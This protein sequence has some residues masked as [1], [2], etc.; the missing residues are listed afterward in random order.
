MARGR[1][2]TEVNHGSVV[3]SDHKAGAI[4]AVEHLIEKKCTNI[5]YIRPKEYTMPAAVRQEGYEEAIRARGLEP[6]ILNYEDEEDL[7][8]LDYT[9]YDGVFAWADVTA[10]S[11]LFHVLKAGISVPDELKLVGFDNS[12]LSGV[13]YPSL[14][15]VSQ[16]YE[17][18]AQEAVKVL[19]GNIESGETD[20]QVRLLPTELVIRET[21]E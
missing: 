8:A 14:T 17:E 10:I 7:S 6:H 13:L 4:Q 20:K 12:Y 2:F 21:T 11:V 16:P 3:S 9:Q 5:L 1:W 19:I 18:M 15:T